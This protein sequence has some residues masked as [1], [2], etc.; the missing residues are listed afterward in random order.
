MDDGGQLERGHVQVESALQK[1]SF[2]ID[3]TA[4]Y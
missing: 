2:D 3:N 4:V 1:V